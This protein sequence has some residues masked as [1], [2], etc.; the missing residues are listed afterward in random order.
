MTLDKELGELHSSE[1]AAVIVLFNPA[2]DFF[3]YLQRIS[4]LF[5]RIV[6][7]DNS[8]VNVDF[9][10]HSYT[11]VQVVANHKNMGIAKA[12]NQGLEVSFASGANYVITFDQD[13]RV[14]DEYLDFVVDNLNHSLL[15]KSVVGSGYKSP[16]QTA[17]GAVQAAADDSNFIWAK[18]TTVITSGMIISKPVYNRV[19]TFRDDYFIDSV[20]QEYCLRARKSGLVVVNSKVPIMEH[21]VGESVSFV[22][23]HSPFRKY[24]IFRNV[25]VTVKIYWAVEPMWAVKQL[26]RLITAF[27]SVVLFEK[28][29]KAKLANMLLGVSHAFSGRMGT[30]D[31]CSE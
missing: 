26:V 3:D 29:K 9:D 7:V 18:C 15:E 12:L 22:P 20:D 28:Q 25:L 31:D 2:S 11:N 8:T 14:S 21:K 4:K 10:I 1:C 24:Y 5:Q 17:V 19:G 27:G 30:K 13:T 6:L 16:Y 23:E